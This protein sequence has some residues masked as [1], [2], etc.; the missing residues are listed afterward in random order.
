MSMAALKGDTA[1]QARSLVSTHPPQFKAL[2]RRITANSV[3]P[4]FTVPLP[5]PPI[6]PIRRLQLPRVRKAED[7][8]RV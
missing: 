7:K 6:F 4:P 1:F 5:P 2:R 3:P 8:R